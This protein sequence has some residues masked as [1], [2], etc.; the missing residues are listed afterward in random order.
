MDTHTE[1]PAKKKEG[2][3]CGSMAIRQVIGYQGR[4]NKDPDSCYSFW[5]GGSLSMLGLFCDSDLPSTESF[6]LGRCQSNP[7]LGGFSKLPDTYPDALH[8]F[9]SICWLSMAQSSGLRAIDAR[10]GIC[11]DRFQR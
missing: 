8:S 1:L 2:L 9:Y 7:Y 11:R 10:L 6:L 4:T 3:T 5:V